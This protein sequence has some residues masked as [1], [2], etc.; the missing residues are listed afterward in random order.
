MA[1]TGFADVLI[2]TISGRIKERLDYVHRKKDQLDEEDDV[3]KLRNLIRIFIAR[4][5]A[6]PC[7]YFWT[8]VCVFVIWT[9]H[10]GYHRP[11]RMRTIFPDWS[12]TVTALFLNFY[13]EFKPPIKPKRFNCYPQ[14]QQCAENRYFVAIVRKN[15]VQ[16]NNSLLLYIVWFALQLWY[17]RKFLIS[18]KCKYE[19]VDTTFG[20]FYES[21][22]TNTL[23][24]YRN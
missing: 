21:C 12:L 6:G 15:D 2:T 20:T 18:Y 24:L 1:I 5:P 3:N 13:G 16:S 19:F 14:Q 22:L 11:H 8:R 23:T 10:R 4:K 9:G 17:I 7:T